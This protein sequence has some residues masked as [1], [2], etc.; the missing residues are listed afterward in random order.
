M[1]KEAESKPHGL[2]MRLPFRLGEKI[3]EGRISVVYEA[4]IPCLRRTCAVKV[5]RPE[6]RDDPAAVARLK[7]EAQVLA[8]LEH[9]LIPPVL[10]M[11]EHPELG[12]YLLMKRVKGETWAD[13]LQ[14][15]DPKT[16]S[17]EELHEDLQIFVKVCDAVAYAHDRG[18]LH[19]DLKPANI[20]LGDFGAVY[21]VDWNAAVLRRGYHPPAGVA[22]LEGLIGKVSRKSRGFMV[23]HV[24][25][26]PPERFRLEKR[27]AS[28]A[29]DI[30]SLGALLYVILTG[31]AAYVWP[32]EVQDRHRP[33]REDMEKLAVAAS[34]VRSPHHRVGELAHPLPLSISNI[35]MRAL[36]ADPEARYASA[37]AMKADLERFLAS[38]WRLQSRCYEMGESVVREGEVGDEAYV[39]ASG[40]CCVYRT[41]ASG[42]KERL[43]TLGPGDLFGEVAAFGDDPRRTATVVA[44][45]PTVVRVLRPSE[46]DS[47]AVDRRMLGSFISQLARRFR[48]LGE[49]RVRLRRRVA[50][51]M[52][53]AR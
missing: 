10:G 9:P 52:Q 38:P 53:G 25:F 27:A 31:R 2:A 20:M 17:A 51:A 1:S 22:A 47:E 35:A 41:T 40:Q 5:L 8:Q 34:R 50:Q 4:E 7:A 37:S 23:G 30:F 33:T 39:I 19:N 48:A 18:I 11:D 26:M 28:S 49:D 46:L 12:P 24:G 13:R 43:A 36:R 45:E 32:H 6:L 3:G 42:R 44:T 14:R 21:L 16:R 29:A 15:I